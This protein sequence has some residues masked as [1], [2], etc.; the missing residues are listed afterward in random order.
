MFPWQDTSKILFYFI[1]N[2]I[3][4]CR[5]TSAHFPSRTKGYCTVA[6]PKTRRRNFSTL[7]LIISGD[8][9]CWN[10]KLLVKCAQ[11]SVILSDLLKNQE[12]KILQLDKSSCFSLCNS[13]FSPVHSSLNRTLPSSIELLPFFNARMRHK[14]PVNFTKSA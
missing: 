5:A 9:L 2:T 6:L 13:I 8:F 3:D 11:I 12:F 4:S 1:K 14:N 7:L 10:R